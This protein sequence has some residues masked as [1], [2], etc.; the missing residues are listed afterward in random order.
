MRLKQVLW[1]LLSNAIKFTEPGGKVR[2]HLTN[3]PKHKLRIEIQDTGIGI[4]PDMLPF[5]FNVFE[6][7]SPKITQRFGGLG[8]GLAIVKTITE[9]HGGTVSAESLGENQGTRFILELPVLPDID[10]AGAEP[11]PTATLTPSRQRILRVLIVEDHPDTARVLSNLLKRAGYSVA[12]ANSFTAGQKLAAEQPFDILVSDIGLPDGNGMDL[13]RHLRE[14][15]PVVGIAITG[16]GTKED[17]AQIIAS[18]FSEVLLKPVSFE[19]L[20]QAIARLV[21]R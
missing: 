17:S 16:Y 11:R 3:I 12:T 8:L 10:P 19:S 7:G 9:S 2:I 13:M 1:N 6:Q 15:Q 4:A 14:K 21:P 5:I 18:G 20:Q